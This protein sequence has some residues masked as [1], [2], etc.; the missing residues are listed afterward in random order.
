MRQTS[1]WTAKGPALGLVIGLAMAGLAAC[2]G[3]DTPP[4]DTTSPDTSSQDEVSDVT[5]SDAAMVE[6]GRAI[7]EMQCATCHAIGTADE[8][9]R[10]DAPPLRTVLADYDPDALADDFREGIHVGHPDMPDFNLGPKGTDSVL[11]YLIS[12]R[13]DD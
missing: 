12:I 5:T 1:G 3:P 4:E 8:S 6:N 10:T 13:A 9:P 7:V 11:A 2:G